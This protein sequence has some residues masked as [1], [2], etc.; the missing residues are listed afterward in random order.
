MKLNYQLFFAPLALLLAAGCGSY[1][2]VYFA[3]EAKPPAFITGTNSAARYL[4]KPDEKQIQLVVYSQLLGR[5]LAG[6]GVYSAIFVQADDD[7]VE[8]LIKKFPSHVPPI[9]QSK[10]IDVRSGKV[11]LDKETGKPVI[12]L[13]ADVGEPATD[14]SV[15]VVGRWYAGNDVKGVSVFSLRK[16]GADWAILGTK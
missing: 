1:D 9:K 15:E 6:G 3:S 11:P 16:T 5:D 4:S 7:V 8:A 13:G 2:P 10:H 12:I 14:G